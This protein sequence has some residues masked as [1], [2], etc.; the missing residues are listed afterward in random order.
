MIAHTRKT[1][2]LPFLVFFFSEKCQALSENY[3]YVMYTYRLTDVKEKMILFLLIFW[4]GSQIVPRTPLALLPLGEKDKQDVLL[5]FVLKSQGFSLR[6]LVAG[7][8]CNFTGEY[9]ES[10]CLNRKIIVIGYRML[11]REFCVANGELSDLQC[12]MNSLS[13]L[14]DFPSFQ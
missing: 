14:G 13:H 3:M 4:Q 5:R 10:P 2:K 8:R 1:K 7:E 11:A 12:L 9:C 6:I